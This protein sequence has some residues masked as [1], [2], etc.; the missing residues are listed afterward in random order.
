[1]TLKIFD[2]IEAKDQA[3]LLASHLPKGKYW[4]K[5]FDL[6]DDF[7]KL[8]LALAMEFYRFQ[9][10][11]QELIIESGIRTTDKKL[12]EWEKS[13]GIPDGIF[14]TNVSNEQR[15]KQAELRFAK[16]NG[17]QTKEDYIR[18]AN[19]FGFDIAVFNGSEASGLSGVT[20]PAEYYTNDKEIKHTVFI[21]LL[22]LISGSSFF[23]LSFPIVFTSSF[24]F[25]K[26]IFDSISPVNVNIIIFT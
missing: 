12:E 2:P 25:L 14:L 19:F 16:Y 26:R 23:P 13:V 21:Q 8:F 15:K 6:D 3:F 10:L 24:S 22:T 7:G 5:A 20:M 4:E 1:M 18:I 11:E 17:A 9:L